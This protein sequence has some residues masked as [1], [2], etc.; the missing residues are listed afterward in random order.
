M[1]FHISWPAQ[2]RPASELTAGCTPPPFVP[3]GRG[4]DL[5]NGQ[6]LAD[7]EVSQTLAAVT[8]TPVLPALMQVGSMFG[9]A[10]LLYPRTVGALDPTQA[11]W[12]VLLSAGWLE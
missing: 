8:T 1:A 4:W 12:I 6:A 5:Q 2:W 11:E 3:Y 7:A 10:V 9:A